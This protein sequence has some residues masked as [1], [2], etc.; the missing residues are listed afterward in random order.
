MVNDAGLLSILTQ[1]NMILEQEFQQEFDVNQN[2]VR[3]HL[4][5]KWMAIFVKLTKIVT[6]KFVWMEFVKKIND[7]SL[8]ANPIMIVLL[9]D[10]AI[11]L[12]E[13]VEM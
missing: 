11:K 8:I 6:P 4:L 5:I 2:R 13:F 10:T 12:Q 3:N 7:Y 9:G 1:M